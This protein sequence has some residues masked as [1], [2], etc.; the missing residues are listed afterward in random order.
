MKEPIEPT[1]EG[2]YL[3]GSPCRSL[4]QMRR[5]QAEMPKGEFSAPPND[6]R[7]RPGLNTSFLRANARIVS[8]AMSRR[9][10]ESR[11]EGMLGVEFSA[12]SSH[13]GVFRL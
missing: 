8:I 2:Y 11:Q 6:L 9:Q 3:F 4:E 5:I 10:G 12:N 13:V 7:L 1:E